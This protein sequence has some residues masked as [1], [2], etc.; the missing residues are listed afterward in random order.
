M[1]FHI[2]NIFEKRRGPLSGP[3]LYHNNEGRFKAALDH[4]MMSRAPLRLKAARATVAVPP[5]A[6]ADALAMLPALA[7]GNAGYQPAA[8]GRLNWHLMDA[9]H[10]I[11]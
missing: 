2:I 8:P 11:L 6:A 7:G 5:L 4:V 3:Q 10:L 9:C 1:A